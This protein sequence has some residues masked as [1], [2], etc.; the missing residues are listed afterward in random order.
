MPAPPFADD[1]FLDYPNPTAVEKGPFLAHGDNSLDS[2]LFEAE[3]LIVIVVQIPV[4]N[5]CHFICGE[6][7]GR[8]E[9]A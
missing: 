3:N 7:L 1:Q 5:G 9:L 8:P 6:R 4:K 2:V